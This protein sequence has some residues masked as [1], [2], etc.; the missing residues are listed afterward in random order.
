MAVGALEPQF[1]SQLVE[2]LGL[3][4]SEVPQLEDGTK[5]RDIFKRKFREKTQQE[6]TEVNS[7][8]YS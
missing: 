3:T 1:Y 5:N 2:K 6:W 7:R 4:M 8:S